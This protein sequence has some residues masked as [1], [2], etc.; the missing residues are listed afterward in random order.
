MSSKGS[1]SF[2]DLV[3]NIFK[4]HTTLN[5]DLP[6]EAKYV[7]EIVPKK[8]RDS[9]Q[10]NVFDFCQEDDTDLF[11]VDNDSTQ[12]LLSE[13][14]AMSEVGIAQLQV[15]SN[16]STKS[17]L[18]Y[19]HTDLS[20]MDLEII[21]VAVPNDWC[22]VVSCNGQPAVHSN[23]FTYEGSSDTFIDGFDIDTNT[24]TFDAIL[25]A[26]ERYFQE[27]STNEHSDDRNNDDEDGA[28]DEEEKD[29]DDE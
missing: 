9:V 19:L 29:D 14:K 12:A 27:F 11:E 18:V 6:S 13:L 15:Y 22:A 20:Y 28:I 4:A 5:S 21:L 8:R 2:S 7:D 3:K 25:L 16:V 23:H 17:S 24:S 10:E 26:A 1:F